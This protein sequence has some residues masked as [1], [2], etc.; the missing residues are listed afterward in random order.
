MWDGQGGEPVCTI[1]RHSHNTYRYGP[2]SRRSDSTRSTTSPYPLII[3]LNLLCT[4]HTQRAIAAL[5]RDVFGEYLH[6]PSRG[7]SNG[8]AAAMEAAA[9][10]NEAAMDGKTPTLSV[11][12]TRCPSPCPHRN[13]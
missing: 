2:R 12:F 3:S 7:S 13:S 1:T 4:P 8:N 6:K 11:V 5:L 9:R 10:A